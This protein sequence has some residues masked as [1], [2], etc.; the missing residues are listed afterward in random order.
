MVLVLDTEMHLD[1]NLQLHLLQFDPSPKTAVFELLNTLGAFSATVKY[2]FH[3]TN[4][5]TRAGRPAILIPC[6]DTMAIAALMWV[7]SL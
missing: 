4:L 5:L 2:A 1:W 7:S 3:K 6:N